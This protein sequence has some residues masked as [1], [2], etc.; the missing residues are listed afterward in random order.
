MLQVGYVIPWAVDVALPEFIP[1]RLVPLGGHVGSSGI[2]FQVVIVFDL[3][4]VT[5]I[6]M[7]TERSPDHDIGRVCGLEWITADMLR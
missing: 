7:G 2:L 4:P 5:L 1:T 6:R 3:G